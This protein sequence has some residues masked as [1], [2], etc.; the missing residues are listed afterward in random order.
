MVFSKSSDSTS[1]NKMF[2]S[3]P[4]G[5][6]DNH[7]ADP[8]SVV[9]TNMKGD[10][11]Q[12]PP[13]SVLTEDL[14]DSS[15]EIDENNQI[16]RHDGYTHP[17]FESDDDPNEPKKV[18]PYADVRDKIER[19]ARADREK[20]FHSKE[21]TSDKADDEINVLNAFA[22]ILGYAI[23]VF[24]GNIRDICGKIFG[25]S[26]YNVSN[27]HA[28]DDTSLYA[29]LLT[30]WEVFYTKRL[31]TRCSDCFNRPVGSNPGSY[32]NVM[33]RVS[34]DGNKTLQFLGS[35]PRE[36]GTSTGE[37]KKDSDVF[38]LEKQSLEKEFT[39]GK[40]VAVEDNRI[41]RKCLNLGS[42]NYLGFGDDWNK[43]CASSVL[44][45]LD[46]LPV[47]CAS[48][49][50]EAGN[51]AYHE[52]LENMIAQFI[53]QEAALVHNMGFNTNN[54]TIP[55][56]VGKKDLIISDEL[57]HTSIVSGARSSGANI[58]I[59]K[60]NDVRSLEEI[61]IDAIVMGR[62]RSRR[63]FK[64]ILVIVEGIYSMEGEYCNLGP[65]NKVCKKY[66]AFLYLDEAHS[67]G[68]MGPTGR[69]CCEYWGVD[70]VDIMMGTFSKSFA[71]MGG[72]VAGNKETIDSLRLNCSSNVYHNSLSPIV[73]KQIITALKIIM[74]KDG[75][76][77]GR[78]KIDSLRDNSNYFRMRL[79]E[80]K[81]QVLGNYDSPVMPIM[82]FV[83]TK[84]PAFSRECF[85]RGLAVVVVGFP[86]VPLIKSRARF[87]ISATHKREELD[88][89]LTEIDE[90]ADILRLRYKA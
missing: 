54:T 17:L 12:G 53:G 26:R 21:K 14:S 29:P 18:D 65:I 83:A 28:S 40:F 30:G 10:K 50:I 82:L 47:S 78:Q 37:N 74:G 59:F 43:T 27:L 35:E 69:G 71:G 72:Y 7:C 1:R 81:V 46:D 56:L 3:N 4:H 13:Q 42:Y 51:T 34:E 66:G 2:N 33:E 5:S 9:V 76:S 86:A 39:D 77:L 8:K 89:A 16:L 58:R 52:E 85:K 79:T 60:H 11:L 61:L 41:A 49:R 87:C 67:I 32:I 48:S 90:V 84:I 38:Y 22:T 25:R 73:C 70:H 23:L 57:N 68:A 64:R 36:I 6:I 88:R 45:C 19:L 63:P 80:M 75:T 20:R 31:Y 55:A 15:S 62:P 44:P 24:V